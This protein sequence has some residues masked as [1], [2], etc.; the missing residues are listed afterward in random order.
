MTYIKNII[1]AACLVLFI[2]G[3]TFKGNEYK[4]DMNTINILND[5]N[6]H[7][8]NVLPKSSNSENNYELQ[9]RGGKMVSPYGS[10]FNDYILSSLKKQLKQNNLYNAESKIKIY[11]K[12]LKNEVDIWG[13]STANYEISAQFLIEKSNDIVYNN[14]ISIKHEFPSHFVGQIAVERGMNNYPK[15]VQKLIVEFLN[16]K[17]VIKLLDKGEE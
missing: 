3:C 6:L 10:N 5:E 13:F 16:D 1:V 15:A 7:Q 8:V 17:N 9:L 14:M 11:T 2:S 12:L 4:S